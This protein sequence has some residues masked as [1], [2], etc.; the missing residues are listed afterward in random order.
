MDP[1]LKASILRTLGFLL[2]ASF[3]AWLFVIV[4]YTEKD[5]REEKY[6]LLYSLYQSLASK[7][8]MSLDEF[9][10]ISNIAYEALSEPKPQ[11]TYVIAVNFV[12]Q[13]L[14][15]IGK[16]KFRNNIKQL[17]RLLCKKEM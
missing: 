13:A 9:N 6:Q 7:Y 10:N 1:L 5:D 16:E 12:W 17:K 8:N 4:E 2:W 3:S 15:T 14:T 11:W